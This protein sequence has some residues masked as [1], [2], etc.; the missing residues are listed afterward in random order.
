MK[1]SKANVARIMLVIVL[2]SLISLTALGAINGI[3]LHFEMLIGFLLGVF[4]MQ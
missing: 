1:M 4:L 2:C 3:D